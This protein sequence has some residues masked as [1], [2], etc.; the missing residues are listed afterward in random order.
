VIYL[1]RDKHAD[2]P[3]LANT[4]T[5]VV[6]KNRWSGD[7]GIACYLYYDPL[8]GRMTECGKPEEA[9]GEF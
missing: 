9:V 7:T 3:I 2:D 8:T 1:E 6:D 5:V 4:T